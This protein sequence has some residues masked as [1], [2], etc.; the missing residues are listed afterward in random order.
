MKSP[1]RILDQIV[2]RA[3]LQRGHRD[4]GILRGR[5]EHHRRRVRDRHD[6]LQRLQPVEARHVLVERDHV[7]AAL[8]AAAPARA[9]RFAACTTL[10][11]SRVRPRS[12]SRASA[13]SS[14]M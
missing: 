13:S 5:D 8:A 11:P 14:S 2:G 10:K 6:L 1:L 3:R 12:T 4:A 7:D 9:R